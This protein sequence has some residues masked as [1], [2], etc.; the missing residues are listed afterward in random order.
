ME[1]NDRSL[2]G[3]E[4]IPKTVSLSAHIKAKKAIFVGPYPVHAVGTG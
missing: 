2:S 1:I 3:V 4:R